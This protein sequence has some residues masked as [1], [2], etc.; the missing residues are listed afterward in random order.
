MWFVSTGEGEEP[1]WKA[2]AGASSEQER[3]TD[4]LRQRDVDWRQTTNQQRSD[5]RQSTMERG[6]PRHWAAF[7]VRTQMHVATSYTAPGM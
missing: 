1:G 7:V 4:V 3:T 2:P 5:R 6:E